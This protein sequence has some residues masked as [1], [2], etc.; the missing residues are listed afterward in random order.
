M[1]IGPVLP[2]SVTMN[3]GLTLTSALD[4]GGG[5]NG[6]LLGI[7]TMTSATD[8]RLRCSPT[9]D[10]TYRPLYLEPVA[11]TQTPVVF[12]ANST[13]TNCYVP[14]KTSARFIKVE[15]TTATTA[16]SHVFELICNG[17]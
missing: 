5:Y 9:L 13:V 15:F 8:I 14:I 11:G 17:N 10:G 7:P 4:L 6:Y 1:T 2:Y 16:S 12:N 3:S